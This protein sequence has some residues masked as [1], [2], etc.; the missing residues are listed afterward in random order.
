MEKTFK[1]NKSLSTWISV[2]SQR[3][4]WDLPALWSMTLIWKKKT[5]NWKKKERNSIT[6]LTFPNWRRTKSTHFWCLSVL[7]MSMG[8]T[9]TSLSVRPWYLP[10]S[11]KNY[12]KIRKPGQN[13]RLFSSFLTFVNI[14]L[15]IFVWLLSA[16]F[17]FWH[18]KPIWLQ[19]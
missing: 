19:V 15:N 10:T 3:A 9:N 14:Y 1:S 13:I 4:L 2:C 18:L 8:N 17:H 16:I 7:V 6:Y 11:A 5:W 12:K